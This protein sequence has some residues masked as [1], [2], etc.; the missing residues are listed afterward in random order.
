MTE[1]EMT[2]EEFDEY[3]DNGGDI[4]SFIDESKVR[5]PNKERSDRRVNFTMPEW[6]IEEL[7][8]QARHLAISRQAVAVTWLAER[9][10]IERGKRL[11]V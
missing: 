3:F 9:A 5:F 10:D 8:A 7:D 11:A 2:T 1:R 6:L 4:T